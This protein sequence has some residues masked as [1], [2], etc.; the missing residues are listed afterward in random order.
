MEPSH[1]KAPGPPVCNVCVQADLTCAGNVV[2]HV[3]SRVPFLERWSLF[4]QHGHRAYVAECFAVTAFAL[5]LGNDVKYLT[6]VRE[7][8]LLSSHR[9]N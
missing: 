3:Q 5:E 6:K 2:T 4:E 8:Q 1:T 7:V 9:G